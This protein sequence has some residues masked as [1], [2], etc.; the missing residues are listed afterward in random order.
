MKKLMTLAALALAFGS[1][2][3]VILVLS[4]TAEAGPSDYGRP[5]C[6]LFRQ[7]CRD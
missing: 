7:L 6:S 4:S 5:Q 1:A 3:P 2:A